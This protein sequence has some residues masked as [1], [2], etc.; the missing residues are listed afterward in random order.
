MLDPW[1]PKEL[2]VDHWPVSKRSDSDDTRAKRKQRKCR[3]CKTNTTMQCICTPDEFRCLHCL[4]WHIS[5]V[6][7]R[8]VAIAR[9]KVCK[10]TVEGE[11]EEE[12]ISS[13]SSDD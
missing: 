5:T 6:E 7:G 13:E 12:V 2:A 10:K 4:R 11:E 1:N 3:V 9:T 8:A